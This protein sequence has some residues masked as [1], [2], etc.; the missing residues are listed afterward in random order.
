MVDLDEYRRRVKQIRRYAAA[1]NV[2]EA[3]TSEIFQSC[4]RQLEAKYPKETKRLSR[5][6]LLTFL[7][8]FIV[9]VILYRSNQ[10]WLNNAFVK[11]SQNS[12]YPALYV[13]RKV[14]VPIVSLYPSLSD[15]YDE[16]CLIENP[17]FYI[18]EMDCWHCTM[19][20]SVPDLTGHNISR[21][22]NIEIPYTKAENNT[23]IRMRDLTNMYWRNSKIFDQDARRI[24]S[25]NKNFKVIRDVMENRLDMYPTK[26]L[27]THVSWRIN[28]MEPN[29]IL[30][31]LF[32]KPVETPNW[33]SQGTEK[34]IFIDESRSPPYT[35]PNPECSNIVIRCAAGARLIKMI[36]SSECA[37]HCRSSIILLS[38]GHT[39]WYNWWYWRPV[40]LP[41][42][43]ATDLSV[44]Y[45]TSFC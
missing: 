18:N 39:L 17:Y 35:V 23:K 13:L 36:P 1:H 7:L 4:F 21:S 31:K 26:L 25:N 38:A 43:N 37:Q 27:D 40:S 8:I 22:F 42:Y 28:R 44:S 15:L 10:R 2:S 3:Q 14:A 29:R 32:P 20:H 6:S 45:L 5:L 19:V 41:V 30:R 16:W 24:S 12:I 11:I 33:W 9:V 34:Y